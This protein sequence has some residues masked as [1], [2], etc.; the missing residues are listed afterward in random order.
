MSVVISKEKVQKI[1]EIFQNNN[2][3]P[4]TELDYENLFTLLVAVSLS[5][6]TTDKAVNKATKELFKIA[7]T[8][9]EILC[10]GEERIKT[11]IKN[12]G[13]FNTKA[14]NIIKLSEIILK[15]YQGEVPLE[16][17]KL[18]KLPGVGRKTANVVLNCWLKAKVMPVDT[19]ILRVSNRIGLSNGKSP[20]KVEKDLLNIISDEWLSYA[21]HWLILHGRYICKARKPE[22]NNCPINQYCNYY[23]IPIYK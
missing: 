11:Y 12:L 16:F 17:E 9:E 13:F 22:C 21:H 3:N 14:K 19:H 6:R 20:E 15:D 23:L 4:E 18:I 2:P 8:P 1:F 5:A 10:L 7:N